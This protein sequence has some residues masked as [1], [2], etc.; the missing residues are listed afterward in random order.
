MPRQFHMMIGPSASGKST[1]ARELAA[2]HHA[3]HLCPDEVR[4]ILVGHQFYGPAEDMVWSHV[5]TTAR[6]IL[7]Q[8]NLI[9][10]ATNTTRGARAQWVRLLVE[11]DFAGVELIGH[12]LTTPE[13]VCRWRNH[14]YGH[15][16]VPETVIARQ[17]GQYVTPRM[18]EGFTRL[19]HY[20]EECIVIR[21]ESACTVSTTDAT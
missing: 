13:P 21:E 17:F 3:I 20:D 15:T 8:R 2:P 18:E 4:L 11:P 10:D 14:Q 6:I 19:I 9:L 1:L 7:P 16:P 12:V 5:K